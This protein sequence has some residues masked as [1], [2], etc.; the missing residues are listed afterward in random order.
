ML[1][2]DLEKSVFLIIFSIILFLVEKKLR[3]LESKEAHYSPMTRRP[4]TIG[5]FF[6]ANVYSAQSTGGARL[7][8][9]WSK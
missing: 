7:N 1:V 5:I 6:Q 4:K 2:I 8:S 9:R 3:D